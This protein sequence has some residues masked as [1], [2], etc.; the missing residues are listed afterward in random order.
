MSSS[1]NIEMNNIKDTDLKFIEDNIDKIKSVINFIETRDE[2]K[3]E[4]KNGKF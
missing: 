1:Y 3:D 4:K 2:E